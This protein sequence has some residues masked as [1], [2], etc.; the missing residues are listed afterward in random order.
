MHKIILSLSGMI[1]VA[2]IIATFFYQEMERVLLPQE[3]LLGNNQ[4]EH[5]ST[6]EQDEPEQTLWPVNQDAISYS[7]QHDALHITFNGGGDWVEVPVEQEQLFQGEYNGNRQTLIEESYI[8]QGDRVAFIYTEASEDMHVQQVMVLYSVDQGETWQEGTIADAF[9]G[10]RYRKID[11]VNNSFGYA[12][13]SGD[14][15][16]SSEYSLAYLTHDGGE[17][18]ESAAE[19]PTTRLIADGG[20]TDEQT[21]FLSYGTINPEKP[22]VYV[23]Q[24]SGKSWEQ[25]VFN[26]PET[27]EQIFVQAE[28]PFIEDDHLAVLVNQGPNGDYQ[29]G[30][31]KG[32]F[33]SKDNGLNWGFLEEVPADDTDA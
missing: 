1:L 30:L 5:T 24:D 2:L 31:L 22:D 26:I 15:T 10:L 3:V 17:T 9:P 25:A 12:I 7:L 8:L 27:Y 28:T 32:K 4:Q 33:I 20:F 13:L 19:T 14:R 11:F 16:M 21:G 6:E 18:W 23:T 29:G